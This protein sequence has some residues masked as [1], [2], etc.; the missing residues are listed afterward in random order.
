[1]LGQL[2]DSAAASGQHGGC[3]HKGVR[4]AIEE[5]DDNKREQQHGSLQG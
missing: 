3:A 4:H 1:M 2:T 5:R